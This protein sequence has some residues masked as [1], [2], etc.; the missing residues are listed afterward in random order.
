MK[1]RRRALALLAATMVFGVS[2]A[3]TETTP[4][5]RAD[6][7]ELSWCTSDAGMGIGTTGTSVAC[8]QFT[9]AALGL[10][11]ATLTQKYDKPTAEAMA[12]FQSN[13]PPLRV[14]GLATPLV[15]TEMGIYS[16]VDAE[17]PPL[18]LADARLGNGS[19]GA[20]VKCLQ[21]KLIQDGF[22]P[23]T[24]K[25]TGTFD[26][27][28]GDGLRAFQLATP[29]LSPDGVAGPSS[30]AALGIWSGKTTEQAGPVVARAPGGPFPAGREPFPNWNL[31]A[32]G[33]P[34]YGNHVPC[35]KEKADII[36][37]EFAKDGADD[38]TQQW[39]TYIASRE[40][41]CNEKTVNNNPATRDDSHCTFQLNALA[42]MFEPHGELGRRGWTT[43]NVKES[44][45]NCADAASDLWVYCGRGPWT[46]PYACAPPWA[47]DLGFGDA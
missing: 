5:A 36:A 15:L 6:V 1:L 42:G 29:P 47:G 16:G 26:K 10:Y 4:V 23:S 33:I 44:M 22:M 7:P 39:A 34:F 31:T 35:T 43:D 14:D 19:K 27:A 28:T 40:G 13:N 17:P 37:N 18:C 46:P 8:L 25:S 24:S 2:A 21:D 20:S 32:D 41:G 45:Q 38:A 3:T 11:H 30:L 9:L 12:I